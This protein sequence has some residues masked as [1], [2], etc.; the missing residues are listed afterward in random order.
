[1][2]DEGVKILGELDRGL[3][4]LFVFGPTYNLSSLLSLFRVPLAPMWVWGVGI[5]WFRPNNSDVKAFRQVFID[6]AYQMGRR[7]AQTKRIQAKY[8]AILA[9]GRTPLIID[10][11]ANVG[12]AALYFAKAFPA[13]R[14]V[15][16]EP[17]PDSCAMLRRNVRTRPQVTVVEGALGAVSGR[18]N[19]TPAGK[20]AWAVR[21]ERSETGC[22]RVYSTAEL[23]EIGGPDTDLLIYKIDIE[24]FERD[25]FAT[26]TDW[27]NDTYAL[28]VELHDWM[29]QG[30]GSSF[31][32]Q[33][34]VMDKGF[35]I[36][37]HGEDLI[38]VRL[39]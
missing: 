17:D 23:R 2:G 27:V 18:V 26:A 8:Q 34:A 33:K 37:L 20:K 35:E 24:G 13:A 38:L 36:V 22:V 39:D 28:M 10:A 29:P 11:G 4:G 32:L 14:L 15:A 30:Q 1:V 31:T 12:A 3:I 19:L 6:G 7:R 5:V 25:L 9:A 16:V 21:T